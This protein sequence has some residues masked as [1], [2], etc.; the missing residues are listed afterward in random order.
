MKSTAGKEEL[1]DVQKDVD[2]KIA[3]KVNTDHDFI[4]IFIIVLKVMPTLRIVFYFA[5]FSDFMIFKNF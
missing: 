1:E 4:V 2:S 3:S 5:Y